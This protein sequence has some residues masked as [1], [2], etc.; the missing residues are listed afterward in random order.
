MFQLIEANTADELWLKAAEWF[1]PGG[2]SLLQ[3]GRSGPTAEVMHAA[4]TLR[5]PRDRWIAS[6]SP[7]MNPAFAIAEV[8]WIMRGR[9]DS[10]FLNY[11]NPRLP[12]FAG[13]GSEFHGAYGFR[14]RKHFGL[15]QLDHA[16]KALSKNPDSRQ[17]V[18]QIWDSCVDL[19]DIHGNP[20]NEDIPCNVAS[21]LKVRNGMLEWTQIMRSNDLIL[22]FPH[23]VVQFTCLQEILAGWLGLEV[24]HYHHL[25]DSF[26]LY[27]KDYDQ[28]SFIAQ[29]DLPSSV[30]SIA[31]P[32]SESDAG[33]ASLSMFG[34]LLRDANHDAEAILNELGALRIPSSFCSW[35]AIL[36]A[37]ALRRRKAFSHM[38][39][40]A[41]ICSDPALSFMFDRWLRRCDYPT[42]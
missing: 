3:P 29:C 25:S 12:Q 42:A 36:A 17:V 6:R 9:N 39:V 40:A 19:P 15:D 34:D 20:R 21:L 31:Y 35:A 23:N 8:I 13:N 37:D 7:A 2:I 22:G 28:G 16:F 18:L 10:A 1:K 11:F 4:F 24:G 30:N 14:L 38:Q 27:K 26:H 41:G 33:F 5:S 32:K